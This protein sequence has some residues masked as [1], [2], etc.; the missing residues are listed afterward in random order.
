MEWKSR[1][2]ASVL[3]GFQRC[4]AQ[5]IFTDVEVEVDNVVFQC[6]KVFLCA[7]SDFFSAMF[8]SGMRESVNNRIQL[9]G[10][11]PSTFRDVLTFYYEGDDKIV[12]HDTVE[13]L[14]RA[15]GLLQLECLQAR[16]ED[17][18][19]A[20]LFPENALGIWKLASCL[21]CKHLEQLAR[22]FLLRHF[23]AICQEAEF[24]SLEVD[25]L[26]DLL[27]D[28]DLKVSSEDVVCTAAMKWV[29]HDLSCRTQHLDA[30]V[31]SLCLHMLSPVCY[32]NLAAF[33][34]FTCAS[35]SPSLLPE[36][37]RRRSQT[38]S[39]S[40]LA[41]GR[42]SRNY[43]EMLV[44]LGVH[45]STKMLPAV[46]AYS[47]TLATWYQ[48]DPLPFDPGV[49]Y[50]TCVHD[51]NVYISGISLRRGYMLRY[52][53]EENF[54]QE[55]TEMPERRRYHELVVAGDFVYAVGGCNK[56]DGASDTVTR[57]CTREDTWKMVGHLQLGVYSASATVVNDVILVFGGRA[58][59]S[60]RRKEIQAF[61]THSNTSCVI[62]RFSS[63]VTES[64]A[65]H[66]G[67]EAF[68]AL[69]NGTVVKVLEDGA[70]FPHANLPN[71][72]RYNFGFVYRPNGLLIVGGETRYPSGLGSGHFADFIQV[73]ADSGKVSVISDKLFPSASA[74][75]C[76]MV[77]LRRTTFPK[78][79]Q[80]SHNL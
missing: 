27:G 1:I 12:T 41:L 59:G 55:V 13:E 33:S 6:H 32:S 10:L 8:Q 3:D 49:G 26:Q 56:R 71:F 70:I 9:S 74:A 80:Q 60:V 67:D 28:S 66:V 79:P 69:T 75:C 19:A 15:A 62:N 39:S 63:P 11:S 50:A 73:D 77:I 2:A 30:L 46:H 31:S 40:D 44:V 23:G 18:Y 64:R 22:I 38:G 34:K 25:A 37:P 52:D 72:D 51:N 14:L 20:H 76:C 17:Y 5:N 57:Y 61:N 36:H 35:C 53:S 29:K 65:L 16:C 7:V 4:F 78:L 21:G 48:L 58:H 24:L 43:E 45:K 42:R 47:F 54:W 68:V